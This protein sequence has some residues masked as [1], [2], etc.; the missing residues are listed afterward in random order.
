MRQQAFPAPAN[1]LLRWVTM[2]VGRAHFWHLLGS[3]HTL[4]PGWSMF[5]STPSVALARLG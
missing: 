1:D 5:A 3:L 4:A 2:G